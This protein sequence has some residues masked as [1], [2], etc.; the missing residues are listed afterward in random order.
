MRLRQGGADDTAELLRLFDEAVVWLTERGSAEQWGTRP[1]SEIPERVEMVRGLASEGL[2]VA[3]SDGITAGALVISESALDY[4]PP[5]D[6]REIYVRLLLTDRRHAG[7]GVGGR[8]LDHART[9]ARE[10][11]ISLVRVDCWSGGDGSLIRYYERQ[12]FTPTVR[13]PVRDKEVQVFE[14]RL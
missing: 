13:V 1:W 11:G 5:V 4:A 6:E 10:R 9:Q 7:R 12:G 8:L 3:E 14:D 2:W